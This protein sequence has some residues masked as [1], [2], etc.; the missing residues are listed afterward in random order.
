MTVNDNVVEI[1]LNDD[2]IKQ[3]VA[4]WLRKT[5]GYSVDETDVEVYVSEDRYYGTLNVRASVKAAKETLFQWQRGI[6]MKLYE[7]R[8]ID[9]FGDSYSYYIYAENIK[10]AIDIAF[11]KGIVIERLTEIKEISEYEKGV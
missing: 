3:A 8:E 4:F 6:I 10:V 2:D 11:K 7:F 1:S 5:G 9:N